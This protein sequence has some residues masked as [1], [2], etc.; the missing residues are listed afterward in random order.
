LGS[1]TREIKRFHIFFI[2]THFDNASVNQEASS[3]L[4]RERIAPLAK[5]L[6][7]IVTG[8]FNTTADKERYLRFTG[9]KENPPQLRNTY[10]RAYEPLV[11][12]DLQPEKRIDHI[13]A[14][15]PCKVEADKW[16]IGLRPLKNGQRMS[17]HD[18]ITVRLCFTS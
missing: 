4:F 17:D 7:I 1:V 12:E 6:P 18:P 2:N 10:S 8:D 16:K 11:S 14:G 13:L 15:G 3:K 9:A 5:G